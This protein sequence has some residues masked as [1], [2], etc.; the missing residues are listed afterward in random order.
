MISACIDYNL[1][2]DDDLIIEALIKY[3]KT[4]GLEFLKKITKND[5][6]SSEKAKQIADEIVE[7]R[8]GK[9]F[10]D[11]QDN[12]MKNIVWESGGIVVK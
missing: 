4:H 1:V 11:I 9:I 7:E 5:Y 2:V 6:R 3:E 10:R 8:G 12:I